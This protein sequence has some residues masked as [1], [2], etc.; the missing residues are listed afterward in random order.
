M[1][2]GGAWKDNTWIEVFWLKMARRASYFS[3][4]T[5]SLLSLSTATLD[6]LQNARKAIDLG[7]S[8]GK[9]KKIRRKKGT[10]QICLQ[11]TCRHYSCCFCNYMQMKYCGGPRQLSI[12]APIPRKFIGESQVTWLLPQRENRGLRN[13]WEMGCGM[14]RALSKEWKGNVQKSP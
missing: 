10:T 2:V 9:T 5:G 8:L 11:P 12:S 13:H 1:P 7:A 6:P 14:H 3:Q 4:I